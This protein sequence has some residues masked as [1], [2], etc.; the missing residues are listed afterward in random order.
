MNK[1]KPN[2]EAQPGNRFAMRSLRCA[3]AAIALLSSAC[4]V[5]IVHPQLPANATQ[6]NGQVKFTS[7][8]EKIVGEIV[9]R[10]DE[11]NLVAEITKGPGVPLLKLSAKFGS[12]PGTGQLTERHMLVVRAT[13]PLSHGGWMWRPRNLPK[14]WYSSRKLKEPSRA[15]A[16]LPEVFMWGDAIATG[17][18]FRVCLPD[19][20]MH[21]RTGDGE[22]L[23][24]DYNRHENPT[25]E[26]LPLKDLRK[27]PVLE[28][29]ICHLDQ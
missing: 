1:T 3:F 25:N 19:I 22:V 4:S 28:G 2:H 14:K 24:F 16:A 27:L 10:H 8:G 26:P 6:R 17:T 18:T 15:W 20:T 9:I 12:D 13:G 11:E 21:A 5:L 23:R 29:V 7:S